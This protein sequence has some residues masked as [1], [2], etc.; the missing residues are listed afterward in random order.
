[1]KMQGDPEVLRLLNEQLTSELTAINQYFLHSKMQDNWGFTELAEHTRAESFDEMRHAEAITDR[2][3]LLDGLPNYQRLFSL[4][5]GQTLRE[6]FEAD[7]AIE[8]EVMDRLKPAIILCREKQ[9][10]TTATLFE[11]IV[12][13][14]EKH[15]DY[16]ET[17][18]ELMDK[19]GVELYSAQCVSRPPS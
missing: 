16:L 18:L 8:Y 1:M 14:E 11:Q 12:A 3:L 4:R 9:D 10:S 15:I 6:Q 17:Q 2:I 13:D 19:L 7:L 5:I